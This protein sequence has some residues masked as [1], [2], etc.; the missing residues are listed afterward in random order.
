MSTIDLETLKRRQIILDEIKT[1]SQA[2]SMETNK[3]ILTYKSVVK[4]VELGT[5]NP[6]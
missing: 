3:G 5:K 1:R 4:E 2:A 6:F